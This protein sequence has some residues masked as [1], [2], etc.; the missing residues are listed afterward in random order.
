MLFFLKKVIPFTLFLFVFPPPASAQKQ[1]PAEDHAFLGLQT[2]SKIAADPKSGLVVTY[3]YPGSAAKEIGFQVGDEIRTLNDLF[4]L[5]RDTFIKELRKENVNAKLRFLIKREGQE[6]N[7]QG[8]I[9]SYRKTMTAYQDVVRK[10]MEGKPFPSFPGLI[11]WNPKTKEWDEK[12]SE[13]GALE[14]KLSVVFSFCSGCRKT[15]LDRISQMK[16]VLTT[17]GEKL[18]VA[19]AGIFHM[20]PSKAEDMKAAAE[21]LTAT[22]PVIP[23]A[24]AFYPGDKPTPEMRNRQ[25]LM[26]NHGVL[27]LDTKGNVKYVQFVDEPEQEF[28][29]AWQKSLEELRGAKEKPSSP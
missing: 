27:I 24:V 18:P 1:A 9:G 8:R 23:I 26:E 25:V 22:P 4:I 7:L 15:K 10:E 17:T 21:I 2:E 14:G 28:F 3:I 29:L 13:M 6:V 16:T 5:D 12:L 11:W 19:F 20:K